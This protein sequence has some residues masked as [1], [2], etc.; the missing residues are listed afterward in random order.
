M[1]A[2]AA[3]SLLLNRCYVHTG[4]HPTEYAHRLTAVGAEEGAALVFRPASTSM[5]VV[6]PAP[7]TPTCSTGTISLHGTQCPFSAKAAT[8]T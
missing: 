3:S 1:R 8:H 6:L 7:L 4:A 2:H 5:S